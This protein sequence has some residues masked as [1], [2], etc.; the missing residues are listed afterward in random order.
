MGNL[1]AISVGM[2]EAPVNVEESINGVL[3]KVMN[4]LF[5]L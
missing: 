2:E 5:I 3:S 1:G 4:A